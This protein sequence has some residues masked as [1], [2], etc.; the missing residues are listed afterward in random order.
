VLQPRTTETPRRVALKYAII[1]LPK[2][3]RADIRAWLIKHSAAKSYTPAT[4]AP[5]TWRDIIVNAY[6]VV[7][8]AD[9]AWI[10]A[11]ARRWIDAEGNL[12]IPQPHALN[13]AYPPAIDFGR[14]SQ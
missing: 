14:R 2:P 8:N 9:R 12:A 13:G 10:A 3:A 11:W 6:A 7:D 5:A 1:A 4:I